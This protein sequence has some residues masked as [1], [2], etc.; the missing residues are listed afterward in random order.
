MGPDANDHPRYVDLH[1]RG[2]LRRRADTAL[3]SLARCEAC[4][5]NCHADRLHDNQP[6]SVCGIGRHAKVASYHAH[7]GEENCLR[8]WNGSGTIFFS[9]CN[10]HCVFCQ[11]WDLS[12]EG[13]GSI[14]TAGQLARMM[15]QLQTQSCHNINFVTPTHVLPQILEALCEAVPAGLSL[16]LVYNTSA[17][18]SLEAIQLLDGIV[19]IYMPDFK[20]WDEDQC[21]RLLNA[22]DYREVACAAIKEMH[23]QVGDLLI[24]QHGLA[25]RGLLVRH[26]VMPND[27]AGTRQIMRFL[28]REISPHT[29]VNIMAQYRP[30]YEAYRHRSINRPLS[31]AEYVQAV[32]AAREEGLHRFSGERRA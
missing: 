7:F 13:R 32:V 31:N 26:L 6:D 23:R 14:V 17:Y 21:R 16:P 15:L 5:R 28:A 9:S 22:P 10:L 19:D 30:E 2:G 3:T 20:I 24:D 25:R 27:V 1:A 8:G 12:W 4:P 18:D 11:N 29:F